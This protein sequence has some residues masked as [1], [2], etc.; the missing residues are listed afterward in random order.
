MS[1]VLTS[2]EA[3]LTGGFYTSP[4]SGQVVDT[5]QP[6]NITWDPT[7]LNTTAVDIYI[8]SLSLT[9]PVL[10]MF[11]EVDFAKGS[12]EVCLRRLLSVLDSLILITLT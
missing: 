6:V 11:Q 7:C 2:P 10:H 1:S 4:T 9:P 3:C 8:Y 12:Y 5:S